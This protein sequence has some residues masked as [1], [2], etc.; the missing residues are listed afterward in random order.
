MHP[1]P[2]TGTKPTQDP[3]PQHASEGLRGP[4]RALPFNTVAK[5][6]Q[7]PQPTL[8]GDLPRKTIELKETVTDSSGPFL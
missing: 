7:K 4:R 5:P 3:D 6:T 8:W 1:D 2:E